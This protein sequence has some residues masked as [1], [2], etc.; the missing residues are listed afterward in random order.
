MLLDSAAATAAAAAQAAAG[1]G[2]VKKRR[3]RSVR[4]RCRC[5]CLPVHVAVA[6][7]RH[8]RGRRGQLPW[9]IDFVVV[10]TGAGRARRTTYRQPSRVAVRPPLGLSQCWRPVDHIQDKLYITRS[11]L[12]GGCRS[13]VP[14][15]LRRRRGA[16]RVGD[17][18][19]PSGDSRVLYDVVG[20]ATQFAVSDKRIF[21]I[22]RAAA[23][24]R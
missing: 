19:A 20:F 12:A 8:R 9:R 24:T 22:L 23:A 13:G 6:R 17:A 16:V 4:L 3:C 1:S 14:L 10:A 7:R 5:L 15:R 2:A 21:M 18:D 11:S